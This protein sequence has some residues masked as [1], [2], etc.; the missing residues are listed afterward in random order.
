[1]LSPFVLDVI[2]DRCSSET[3]T[4]EEEEKR[5]I[6]MEQ[7]LRE[8]IELLLSKISNLLTRDC[9]HISAGIPLRPTA[10]GTGQGTIISRMTRDETGD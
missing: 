10:R 4:Q 9:L 2:K 8:V 3:Q 7:E 1:M 6:T 5:R